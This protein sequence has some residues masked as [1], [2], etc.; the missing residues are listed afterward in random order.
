MT[1]PF[2]VY[3]PV[4]DLLGISE[5]T[6]RGRGY[7]ETLAYGAYTGG[8]RELVKMT[9]AQID[10][11]QRAMLAHPANNWNSSALGLYQ[12]VRKTRIEIE[13]KLKLTSSMLFDEEM[14]DRMACYLLGKRGIDKWLTG[15]MTDIE[16]LNSLAKEWASLPNS[17][18]LGH[19]DGQRASVTVS[20]VLA[21]L[22][23]VRNRY[24]AGRAQLETK[25]PETRPAPQAND[26]AIQDKRP[27]GL[28]AALLAIFRAIFGRGK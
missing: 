20:Q 7:N 1:D 2:H 6:A 18:G 13:Q 8:D 17:K 12:I 10:E 26:N 3:R 16:M 5:G 23:E 14:Q 21:A 11:L 24:R 27:G 22:N 15:Q 19:Y 25:R 9:L 28:V 4:L